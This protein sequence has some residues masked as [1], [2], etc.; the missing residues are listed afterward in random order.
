MNQ[1]LIP[2]LADHQG[3]GILPGDW[4]KPD[5][6]MTRQETRLYVVDE[7][8]RWLTGGRLCAQARDVEISGLAPI[9]LMDAVSDGRWPAARLFLIAHA[10]QTGGYAPLTQDPAERYAW[11]AGWA[12]DV[13]E[14]VLWGAETDGAM[15]SLAA[16]FV[17][18]DRLPGEPRTKIAAWWDWSP[19]EVLRNAP[20]LPDDS[21]AEAEDEVEILEETATASAS[22]GE[23]EELA[24]VAEEAV[25]AM[26]PG[27]EERLEAMDDAMA[28]FFR[29]SLTVAYGGAVAHVPVWAVAVALGA[30]MV[31]LWIVGFLLGRQNRS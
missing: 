8:R 16:G 19:F 4:I 15:E 22:D 9:D 13:C 7:T 26:G 20:P 27:F 2:S 6:A 21:E 28:A 12:A 31:Q 1:H 14:R 30:W 5:P 24:G 18:V 10:M 23:S 29:G 11:V 17:K 25:R 3:L